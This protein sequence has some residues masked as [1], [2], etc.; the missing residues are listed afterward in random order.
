MRTMEEQTRSN[1]RLQQ[2]DTCVKPKQILEYLR[3]IGR[4]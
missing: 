2:F 3:S 1:A 4:L